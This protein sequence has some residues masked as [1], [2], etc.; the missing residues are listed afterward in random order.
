[1]TALLMRKVRTRSHTDS[2]EIAATLDDGMSA[3]YEDAGRVKK[4]ATSGKHDNK[5]Q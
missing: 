2:L 1:M 3:L 4:T 5:H